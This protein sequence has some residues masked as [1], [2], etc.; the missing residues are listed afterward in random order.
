MSKSEEENSKDNKK[1][2]RKRKAPRVQKV[3]VATRNQGGYRAMPPFMDFDLF[4]FP[5]PGGGLPLVGHPLAFGGAAAAAAA[6]FR[7]Y[8]DL[9][10]SD[11]EEGG[12]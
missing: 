8:G 11:D 12:R 5:R 2:G 10:D 1:G 9:F 3:R 7:T 4:A 6:A